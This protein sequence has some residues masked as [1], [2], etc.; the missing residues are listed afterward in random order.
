[1]RVVGKRLLKQRQRLPHAVGIVHRKGAQIEVVGA[2]IACPA[3]SRAGGLGRLQCR[4]DD[5]RDARR[6]LILQIE[7]IFERAV[8][9]VGPEML[10]G[11]RQ[12]LRST[13][14]ESAMWLRIAIETST[15]TIQSYRRRISR[16]RVRMPARSGGRTRVL[17]RDAHFHLGDAVDQV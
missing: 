2:E 15:G 8:K 11:F 13:R 5:P 16:T 7:N 10:T 9:A 6:H 17:C 12:L 14:R 3:T 1:M 4:L